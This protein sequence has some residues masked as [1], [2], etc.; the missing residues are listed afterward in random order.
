MA[1]QNANHTKVILGEKKHCPPANN[2][3]ITSKI[4]LF[5]G[6]NHLL[7]TSSVDDPTLITVQVPARVI[8]KV[9]D[10]QHQWLVGGND[11]EIWHF[12]KLIAWWLVGAQQLF[13]PPWYGEDYS[14]DVVQYNAKRYKITIL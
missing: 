10:H 1:L 14:C 12:K 8:I 9:L 13:C 2:Y 6:H 4:V 11:L 3:A 7:T 5:P